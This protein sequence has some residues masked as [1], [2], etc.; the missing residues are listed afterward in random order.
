MR[1]GDDGLELLYCRV[2]RDAVLVCE[3]VVE[4]KEGVVVVW[5]WWWWWWCGG[6]ENLNFGRCPTG[7]LVGLRPYHSHIRTTRS[8]FHHFAHSQ[9][10]GEGEG[11]C[12]ALRHKDQREQHFVASVAHAHTPP[13]TA[14][15]QGPPAV[16]PAVPLSVGNTD[17]SPVGGSATLPIGP[18][19]TM[20][21]PPQGS[22][23]R[24]RAL[25]D[26][27]GSGSTSARSVAAPA[28]KLAGRSPSHGAQGVTSEREGTA[29]DS[30]KLGT[31][32]RVSERN[33]NK[34]KNRKAHG[35][36]GV[37]EQESSKAFSEDAVRKSS[38]SLLTDFYAE[39][40]ADCLASTVDSTLREWG[41]DPFPDV[42]LGALRKAHSKHQEAALGTSESCAEAMAKIHNVYVTKLKNMERKYCFDHFDV[43]PL[44]DGDFVHRPT[45]LV[46]GRYSVGKT[47]M[48][49]NLIGESYHGSNVGPQ[50]TTAEFVVICHS[51]KLQGDDIKS[52]G[53]VRGIATSCLPNLGLQGLH[54]FGN[55]FLESLKV[56]YSTATLLKHITFVDT[57][58]IAENSSLSRGYNYG[59]VMEWWFQRVDRIVLVFDAHSL[60]IGKDTRDILKALACF[61]SKC[62]VVLNKADQ[63]SP[64]DFIR[65]YGALTWQLGS[66]FLNVEPIPIFCGS[67][68]TS[69]RS[70][71]A[72]SEFFRMEKLELLADIGSVP[73]SAVMR[74]LSDTLSRTRR[75]QVHAR[76]MGSLQMQVRLSTLENFIGLFKS[77]EEAAKKQEDM[78]TSIEDTIQLATGE[79]GLPASD[80]FTAEQYRGFLRKFDVSKMPVFGND[81]DM[82]ALN[83]VYE[84]HIP[85]IM[86]IVARPD[87]DGK[88][89]SAWAFFGRLFVSGEPWFKRS[90]GPTS[91]GPKPIRGAAMPA[92]RPPTTAPA[93]RRF[94]RAPDPVE[95]HVRFGQPQA[96]DSP[97][98]FT[99]RVRNMFDSAAGLV[100]WLSWLPLLMVIV[101]YFAPPAGNVQGAMAFG[102]ILKQV[103]SFVARLFTAI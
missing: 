29:E 38:R 73:R 53:V 79:A 35:L 27:G 25:F 5:W 52:R 26:R 51:N 89:D 22:T 36:L 21:T 63:I 43:T 10:H 91:P 101:A 34:S 8:R 37:S 86:Y 7:I 66:V 100:Q 88:D 2:V 98:G 48:I 6:G 14:V 70:D 94:E 23:A 82:L 33:P 56:S 72:L 93:P 78:L 46:L 1:A 81:S 85:E 97:S 68:G 64:T 67:F 32:D 83:A 65:V 40:G 62:R 87:A 20:D 47:S 3:V 84:T 16:V 92:L 45:V 4:E 15:T 69:T 75:L 61:K 55:D 9:I 99:G 77:D 54:H 58:G 71:H 17:H 49:E 90:V 103:I 42:L 30:L 44:E 60:E 59:K 24:L 31:P 57:P 11:Q 74:F 41:D 19:P 39:V 96:Q 28:E 76:I 102:T 13:A 50:Q 80:A 95:R 12:S 18:L